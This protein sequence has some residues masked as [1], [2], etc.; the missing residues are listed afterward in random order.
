[1]AMTKAMK[2]AIW[3]QGFLDD[4]EIDQDLLKINCDSMSAIYLAK[5]QIYH[6]RMKHID[7]RFHFVRD[8]LNED[9][10]KLQ[11][12]HTKKNPADMLTKAIS[13]MKFA[14][15]KELLLILQVA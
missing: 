7:I 1:M 13:G 4:L 2:E 12:I 5:N 8:I 15:Y 3:L 6:V 11:K 10:I 14:H 9:D